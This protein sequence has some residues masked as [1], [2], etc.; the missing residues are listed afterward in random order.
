MRKVL[1]IVLLILSFLIIYF[2]QTNLFSWFTIANVMPNL[3]VIFILCIGLFAGKKL[4][5]VFGIICGFFLDVVIGR[6]IGISGIMLGIIGLLGEYLDKNFSKESR[7]TIM[8][9]IATSTA[10]YEIGCYIFNIFSLSINVE[11]LQFI[12]ILIIEII[13][14][15][16][17]KIVIYSLIQRLGHTLEE[18]FKTKNILT[19]YFWFWNLEY[20]IFFNFYLSA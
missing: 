8:L 5:L 7:I 17:I 13:Y 11:I 4:G 15:L 14:N 6:Q 20:S 12:K 1:S 19:R 16:L 10:I 9:M 2:I 18:I 3:F